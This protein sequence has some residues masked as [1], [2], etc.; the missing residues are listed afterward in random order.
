MFAQRLAGHSVARI[1]RALSTRYAGV[2]SCSERIIGYIPP[3]QPRALDAR[4]S[5][6]GLAGGL[7]IQAQRGGALPWALLGA[8]SIAS[9]AANVVAAEPTVIGRMITTWPSGWAD[10]GG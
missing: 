6:L 9:L 4:L 2:A 1:T 8:G 7:M 10:G 5:R 3:R